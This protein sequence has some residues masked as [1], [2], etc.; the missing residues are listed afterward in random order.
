MKGGAPDDGVEAAALEGDLAGLDAAAATARPVAG[1]EDDGEV[2]RP[3]RPRLPP[4]AVAGGPPVAG[5][6]P[7]VRSPA[8]GLRAPARRAR[9]HA[10][11]TSPTRFR[12]TSPLQGAATA[13]G[14][15]RR[16]PPAAT[17]PRPLPPPQRFGPYPPL[18]GSLFP[19]PAPPRRTLWSAAED[20]ARRPELDPV[21]AGTRVGY[22]SRTTP[23]PQLLAGATVSAPTCRSITVVG[24]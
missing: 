21:P 9:K 22:D 14:P 17:P 12:G 18:V 8:A 1:G 23:P 13:G 5:R 4:P 15:P 16:P 6:T 11:A 20:G 2:R 24:Y 10:A 19:H 3:E 7:A